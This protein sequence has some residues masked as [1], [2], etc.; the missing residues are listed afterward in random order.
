MKT[1]LLLFFIAVS[2][3]VVAQQLSFYFNRITAENGLSHNKVNCII[4]DRRG[5]VWL[6]TDDGLNRY[7]GHHFTIFRNDPQNNTT[8]SGNIITDLLEDENGIIWIATADGGLTRYNFK[9]PLAQQFK[10]YKHLPGNQKSIPGN[11]INQLLLDKQGYLWLATS[12]HFV[13]RFNREKEIFEIPVQKGTRTALSLALDANEILWVGRQGGGILKINTRTLQYEMDQR[14]DNLYANLPHATVTALYNDL[15]NN[16]WFGSW[17]K[18]MYQY[19]HTTGKETTV[20]VSKFNDEAICFDEDASGNLWIGGRYNGLYFMSK[21]SGRIL[22]F[23]YD[24]SREG[25][26]ASNR[27]NAV[28][29]AVKGMIWI[30]TNEGVSIFDA[31]QHQFEQMF[32]PGTVKKQYNHL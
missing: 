1:S 23:Q 20:D 13:L 22:Q 6:G 2:Q 32:L 10:Q 4:S 8:I 19:N 21:K 18:V 3:G 28:F 26:I 17:D 25:T 5:F 15:D 30:G 29:A 9:L 12:G 27:V 24:P 31:S 7:D 16:I 11:I 14:Y